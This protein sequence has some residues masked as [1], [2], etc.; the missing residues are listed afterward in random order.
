[1]IRI[2]L[3]TALRLV[4]MRRIFT[5]LPLLAAL[6]AAAHD[7]WLE[8]EGNTLTLLHGHKHSA[9]AGAETLPYEPGFVKAAL[10]VDTAGTTKPLPPAK[11][12]P[13]KVA[14]DCATL[15]VAV[16]SGYWTKTPWETKNVPNTGIAGTLKSWLSEE[17]VKR[18]E[19]WTAAASE[20]VGDGLEIVP[21]ASPL[22]LKPDDK[23]TVRVT[24]N[25]KP[26]AG[27]PVAYGG[28]V[29]GA[30]GDDGTIAIR[31]RHSGVQ[32][33]TTSVETPLADGKADLRIQS[34]TLQFD[35]PK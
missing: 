22:L 7:L 31:V 17:S 26:K 14:T 16:S 18:I 32:L 28:D 9:H 1:M 5:I 20:P 34:A 2:N 33:I 3:L 27:V 11:M 29:R 30:T 6:P 25:R 19:H 8:K 24:E 21:L 35:L 4:A 10:C 15:L 23:L 13:W 12:T